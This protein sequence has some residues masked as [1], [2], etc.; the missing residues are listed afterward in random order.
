MPI[1]KLKSSES[2]IFD[3][4]VEIAKKADT[5]KNMMEDLGI[6]EDDAEP[7]PLLIVNT[8]VLKKVIQWC[9]YHKDDPTPKDDDKV[10]FS[11][12]DTRVLQGRPGHAN[13]ATRGG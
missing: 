8:A 1:V 10:D 5:I 11:P 12:W 2:D 13:T 7:L 6:K 3:V 4:D 9:T